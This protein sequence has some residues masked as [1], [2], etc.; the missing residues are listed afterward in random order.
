MSSPTPTSPTPTSLILNDADLVRVRMRALG[1]DGSR[2]SDPGPTASGAD[3][4]RGVVDH[5][6]AIQGQDWRSSK[7]AIGARAPGMTA[8]DVHEALN[9]RLIVR[10]WPM[11]GTVHLV[12]AEDIGWMQRVTN[13]RVIAGAAKRREFLGMSDA[14]LERI[15]DTTVQ[16]L[17][18][19]AGLTR[20]ELG[21]VWSDAGIEWQPN[22][23]YHLIWWLCQNGLT[24]FGPV[25]ERP[26]GSTSDPEPRI[27]LA[28]EWISHPRNLAGDDAL[29]ELAARYVNGRG[30]VTQK[31]L[32]S[33]ANIPAGDAKQALTLAHESGA[34][35]QAQRAGSA[36]A[37]GRLWVDPRHLDAATTASQP[38]TSGW[39]LL[40]AFDEHLLGYNN[41]EPQLAPELLSR[42][43]PGRN[44]I[45]LATVVHEGSVVG[46][47]R[48]NAKQSTLELTP[49]PGAII[50]LSALEPEITRLAD[51]YDFGTSRVL[52]T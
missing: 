42:T 33:W 24:T 49:F 20:D 37:A 35:V 46:T 51:F 31:D 34:I 7:W 9:E 41:R 16:A 12:L 28:S 11:R 10:S 47:W 43:I 26:A 36:G 45:F 1:L 6:L 22:W 15:T 48:R 27:V 52:V 5:L 50:D 32:A 14:V 13:A 30:A 3:R 23:R 21:T 38:A 18:G 2:S 25:A 40:P 19:S 29:R 8:S 17:T 39:Q 44:G 4:A